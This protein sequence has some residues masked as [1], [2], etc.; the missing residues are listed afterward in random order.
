M[1]NVDSQRLQTLIEINELINTDTEDGRSLLLTILESATRLTGGEAS[2]LLLVHPD[3]GKLYFEIALG[4]KGAEVKKYCLEMGEGIAGWVAQNN[5]SLLVNDVTQD[6]RFFEKISKQIGFPTESILAVPMRLGNRCIGVIEIIN[7]T[8]GQSFDQEDLKWLEVFANQAALAVRNSDDYRKSQAEKAE[9]YH[10]FVGSGR[11]ILKQLDL[12]RRLGSSKAAV[13]ILGESG[14]G[15]ELFAEQVHLASDRRDQP[16]VRL[17]C[18][19]LPGD[20]LESELFGH[21][22]GAFTDAVKERIGRFE[23]AS[24]GSLF[25]DEIG[26]LAL[27]LQAKL[28]RILQSGEYEKLGSSETQH[29]DVRII[30]ATNKDLEEEMDQGRFRQDLFYRL[31]VLPLTV[32]PLREHPEDIP[33]L[34]RFFLHK[35]IGSGQKVAGSFSKDAIDAL[36]KYRWPGN[37]RELENVIERSSLVAEGE[38]IEAEDL[39]LPGGTGSGD[40]DFEEEGLK[41]AVIQFKRRFLTKALDRHRWNQTET[42]KAVGIQRTYLSKLIK[43]LDITR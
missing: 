41:E 18:A 33:E 20:L 29:A 1:L 11:N 4:A 19:A 37:I 43:E 22:K 26:E 21:V 13:L 9:G 8:D 23:L 15:K 39:M 36:L 42:A 25:L 31:S 3:N 34:A 14:S 7:R 40:G 12:A 38:L 5:R 24:G 2:S 32:P 10:P 17:N 16:F 30:A 6:E 28:L 27:P 35:I